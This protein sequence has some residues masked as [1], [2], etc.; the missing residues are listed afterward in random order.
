MA[1]NPY[2][3]MMKAWN[4]FKVPTFDYNQFASVQQRNMEAFSAANQLVAEGVQ[5]ASRRQ[6]ELA[7]ANMEELLKTT[8]EMMTGASPE[9]NTKKQTELAKSL[10]DSSLSNMR[11]MSEMFAKS[12]FEA[13]DII[14]KRTSESIDEFQKTAK[15]AA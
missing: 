13:F 2:A 3:D 5:T 1:S 12:G 9:V 8:K 10:F 4:Q 6:A 11:E 14:N 7:R 15:N